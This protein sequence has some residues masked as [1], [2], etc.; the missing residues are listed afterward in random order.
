VLPRGSDKRIPLENG[1]V[2]HEPEGNATGDTTAPDWEKIAQLALEKASDLG[3]LRAG[4]ASLEAFDEPVRR[5]EAFLSAGRDGSMRYLSHRQ[6]D[7]TLTRADPRF[8]FPEARSAIVVALAYGL[9]ERAGGDE[10]ARAQV[11]HYARGDDYHLV[12]REKL[13]KLADEV[14]RLVGRPIT[15]RACVDSAPLLERDLAVRAGFAFLGKNTLAIAPGAG[16][17]FLLGELLVDLPHPPSQAPA[18]YGCGSCTA[19][20]DAC[21]TQAFR[22]PF[23]LDATR[24]ISYLTIESQA[25]IPRELREP[26][27]EHLFGCDDCQTVCPFNGAASKRASAPELLAHRKIS[28]L[29]PEE[30]L[31]LGSAAHKKLVKGSALRRVSRNQL[32][33]NAAVVLGNRGRPDDVPLL[34]QQARTHPS[35]EVRVHCVWALGRILRH[36]GLDSARVALLALSHSERTAVAEE[37]REALH[38]ELVPQSPS[39]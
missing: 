6:A 23:E 3:F 9:G 2:R 33:R 14:A 36:Q 16:S 24:C 25:D 5:L 7:G 17:H 26:M 19:C 15:A 10:A 37:A 20:L 12:I 34:E 1:I 38:S 39:N 13:L 11:A 31:T 8:L 21:P 22:G 35:S 27:G 29:T 28:E 18:I 30:A 4:V 32:A